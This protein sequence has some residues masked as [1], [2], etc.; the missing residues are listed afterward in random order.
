[1][2]GPE[3]APRKHHTFLRGIRQM[4]LVLLAI[5]SLGLIYLLV[6]LAALKISFCHY[7]FKLTF[8]LQILEGAVVNVGGR[9]LINEDMSS[10]VLVLHQEF[11]EFLQCKCTEICNKDMSF[12]AGNFFFA[13]KFKKSYN[14]IVLKYGLKM[15]APRNLYFTSSGMHS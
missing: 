10:R 2:L 11:Q 5:L 14:V 3:F 13:R 4:S 7:T 9:D 8:N 15:R 1:M 6:T 12:R